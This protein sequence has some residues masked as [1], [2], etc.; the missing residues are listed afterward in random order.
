MCS[1]LPD[2]SIATD[3]CKSLYIQ[4]FRERNNLQLRTKPITH[5]DLSP[6]HQGSKLLY[7]RH[8]IFA[9]V[10]RTE[11]IL[12]APILTEPIKNGKGATNSLHDNQL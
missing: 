4:A 11:L 2:G 1:N 3:F 10:F 9:E 6:S 5:T 12:T 8:K 7:S